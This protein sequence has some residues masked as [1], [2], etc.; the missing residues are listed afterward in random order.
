MNRRAANFKHSAAEAFNGMLTT[1]IRGGSD[2]GCSSLGESHQRYTSVRFRRYQPRFLVLSFEGILG[3]RGSGV[4]RT[5]Q[6][7]LVAPNSAQFWK[8]AQAVS[9]DLVV[10]NAL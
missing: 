7:A 5:E 4:N 3:E 9:I 6:T 8:T 10:S 2:Y 1:G